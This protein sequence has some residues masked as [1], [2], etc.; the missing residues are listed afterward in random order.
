MLQET[1]KKTHSMAQ[2]GCSSAVLP[3]TGRCM[4]LTDARTSGPKAGLPIRVVK[5][6]A[7]VSADLR[8]VRAIA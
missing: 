4:L 2:A 6:V 3:G 1:S 7:N 5:Q 8:R